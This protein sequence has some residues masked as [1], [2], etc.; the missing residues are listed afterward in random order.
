V[1]IARYHRNSCYKPDLSGER[2]QSYAPPPGL[3]ITEPTCSSGEVVRTDYQEISVS[4]P[5]TV[6]AGELDV[7][8]G[9]EA[10]KVFDFSADPIPVNATDLVL[11]VAY[12]GPLGDEFDAVAVGMLDTREPTFVTFWNNTDYWWN[13]SSWFGHNATYPFA[14]VKDFWA[15]AGGPPVKLVF[16]YQGA[17]G[18]PAMLNP[19]SGTGQSG[20]VRLGFIFPPPDPGNPS[21]RKAI[22]GVPVSYTATGAPRIP[23]RSIFSS[24]AFRQANKERVLAATLAAPVDTCASAL[25]TDPEYWCFSTIQKRRNQ[26]LGEPA[27][28][29]Y[30]EPLG[31]PN[32]ASDVDAPP[33]QSSFTGLIPLAVG[34]LRFNTDTVLANCPAQ[35]TSVGEPQ[36]EQHIRHLELLEEANFLGIGEEFEQ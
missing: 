25:P 20:I 4:A 10:E 5:L 29:L 28:P 23:Q 33:A 3:I 11:Q 32:A 18:S 19:V 8:A 35:P 7:G 31:T 27:Q 30:L 22:R 21:Q 16:Y 6:V 34:D 15:C 1:A 2:V 14:S 12:R 24:G 9:L 17:T 13:G 26:L 36:D